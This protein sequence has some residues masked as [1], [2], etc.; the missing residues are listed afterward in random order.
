[1]PNRS[2]TKASLLDPAGF[3]SYNDDRGDSGKTEPHYLG[4]VR[5]VV[6]GQ[7]TLVEV[8]QGF[9]NEDPLEIMMKD[10]GHQFIAAQ[11]KDALGAPIKKAQQ[12][13][14]VRLPFIAGVEPGQVLRKV[15]H[16]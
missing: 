12:C 9:T 11:L 16:T 13:S 14:L 5:K 8:G 4:L 10:R 3:S 6:P 7:F 2:Y 1:M 15:R